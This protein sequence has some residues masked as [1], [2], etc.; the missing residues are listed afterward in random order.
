MPVRTLRE[1]SAFGCSHRSL[2]EL[3]KAKEYI[4]NAPG[5]VALA[6]LAQHS[7]IIPTSKP[8]RVLTRSIIHDGRASLFL[9]DRKEDSHVLDCI[10][11]NPETWFPGEDLVAIIRAA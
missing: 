11:I 1:K 6:L 7:D 9:I 2:L 8:I 5:L 10:P 3:I 4:H